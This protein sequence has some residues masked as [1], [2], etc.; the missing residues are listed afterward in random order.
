[1]EYTGKTKEECSITI[2]NVTV[3]D[4]CTGAVRMEDVL[5]RFY[6]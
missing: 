5:V 3:A 1:M 6:E 2:K 4:N